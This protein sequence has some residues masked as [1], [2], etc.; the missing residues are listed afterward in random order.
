[1]IG[2]VFGAFVGSLRYKPAEKK[3]KAKK[4]EVKEKDSGEPIL[5]KGSA[6]CTNCGTKIPPGVDFCTNCG[7]KINR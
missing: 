6:V 1:L 5:D 3:K 4:K 7:A 2:S